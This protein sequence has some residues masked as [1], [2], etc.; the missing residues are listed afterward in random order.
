MVLVEVVVVVMKMVVAVEMVRAAVKKTGHKTKR[1]LMA[2]RISKTL[3][4]KTA[5]NTDWSTGPLARPFARSFACSLT[6]LTPSLVG[7]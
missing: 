5:K 3:W 4:S 1:G 6:S 7:Q 2:L